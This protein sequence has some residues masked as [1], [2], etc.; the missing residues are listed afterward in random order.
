MIKPDIHTI[1][2]YLSGDRYQEY[3]MSWEDIEYYGKLQP[4]EIKEIDCYIEDNP[5]TLSRYIMH[6]GLKVVV[7]SARRENQKDRLYA[8]ISSV[9]EY[10][11]SVIGYREKHNA[12]LKT[13][14]QFAANNRKQKQFIGKIKAQGH[15]V[16]VYHDI[17]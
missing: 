5:S 14:K 11:Q 16:K 1:K 10:Y 2:H 12:N 6:R 8:V 13:K 3:Q 7:P 17:L 4:E 9:R 15:I